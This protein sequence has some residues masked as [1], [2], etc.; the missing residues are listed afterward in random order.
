MDTA[1]D[2]AGHVRR[3]HCQLREMPRAT[4]Q[5]RRHSRHAATRPRTRRKCRLYGTT[6]TPPDKGTAGHAKRPEMPRKRAT[7]PRHAPRAAGHVHT[8]GHGRPDATRRRCCFR[9]RRGQRTRTT[10]AR[11]AMRTDGTTDTAQRRATPSIVKRDATTGRTMFLGR[12]A[13]GVSTR[14]RVARGTWELNE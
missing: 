2:N 12:P 1:R 14:E 13:G 6:D 5:R 4:A 10:D 11:H 3:R 9:V 8:D 7:T